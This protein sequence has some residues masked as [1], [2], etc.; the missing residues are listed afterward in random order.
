[1]VNTAEEMTFFKNRQRPKTPVNSHDAG[2][3]KS[4][5]LNRLEYNLHWRR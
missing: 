3:A 1:M 2:L 5:K 4:K